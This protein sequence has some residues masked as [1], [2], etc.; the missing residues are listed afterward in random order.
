VSALVALR[1]VL[2]ALLLVATAWLVRTRRWREKRLLPLGVAVLAGLLLLS[3]R[4]GWGELA[5]LAAVVVVPAV[6]FAP[7]R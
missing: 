6:L 4:V 7:R 5:V 2:L 3:R 1:A